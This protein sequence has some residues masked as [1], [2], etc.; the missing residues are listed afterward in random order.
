M[1]ITCDASAEAVTEY[2]GF[3]CHDVNPVVSINNPVHLH[4]WTQIPLELL[5]IGGA[6]FAF[7]HA[8]R[9]WRDGDGTNLALCLGSLDLGRLGVCDVEDETFPDL[10]AIRA[11]APR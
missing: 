3:S 10:E 1:S 8:F 9:R 2:L 6:V 4:S 7:V 5:I 11:N